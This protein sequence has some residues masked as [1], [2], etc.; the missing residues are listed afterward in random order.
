[1]KTSS[2]PNGQWFEEDES[3]V[4]MGNLVNAIRSYAQRNLVHGDIQPMNIFVLAD[5]KENKFKMI[6]NGF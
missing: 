3:W 4:M 6:D 1:M 5:E 2:S